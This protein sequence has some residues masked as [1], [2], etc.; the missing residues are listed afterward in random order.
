MVQSEPGDRR[1]R[2]ISARLA[3]AG[4]PSAVGDGYMSVNELIYE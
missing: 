4:S 1:G 2:A 3:V